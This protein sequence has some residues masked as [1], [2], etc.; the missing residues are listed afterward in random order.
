M[1]MGQ[2]EKE[3]IGQPFD[4][5]TEDVLAQVSLDLDRSKFA[6]LFDKQHFDR[7]G[8][9]GV[10][11]GCELTGLMDFPAGGYE[12]WVEGGCQMVRIKESAKTNG[13]AGIQTSTAARPGEVYRLSAKVR[14]TH[15]TGRSK[16]RL[17][18]SARR[19]DGTQITEFNEKQLTVTDDPVLL[20]VKATMPPGTSLLTARAKLHT[21]EPGEACE[22]RIHSFK[23]ERA[24]S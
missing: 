20:E 9:D 16:F 21:S 14:L 13:D 2:D 12:H 15:K 22:G 6:V 7:P 17:N 10:A 5:L 11:D 3:A 19:S 24:K 23:L 4:E 1:G 8:K 18:L